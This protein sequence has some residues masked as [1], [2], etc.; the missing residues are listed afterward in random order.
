MQGD[1]RGPEIRAGTKTS[2]PNLAV[3]KAILDIGRPGDD[4]VDSSVPDY[5]YT[6]LY[7][8]TITNKAVERGRTRNIMLCLF[9]HIYHRPIAMNPTRSL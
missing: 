4:I 9:S 2:L 1:R 8:K 7:P 3:L 5:G 6:A